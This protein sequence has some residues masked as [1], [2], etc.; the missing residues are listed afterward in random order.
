M[1]PLHAFEVNFL[2]VLVVNLI[3]LKLS[4]GR[5]LSLEAFQWTNIITTLKAANSSEKID[6]ID[7]ESFICFDK[8]KQQNDVEAAK[9]V[10]SR[11]RLHDGDQYPVDLVTFPQKVTKFPNNPVLSIQNIEQWICTSLQS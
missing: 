9:F 10:F 8:P 5:P 3:L 2:D 4:I 7:L 6:F 1:S 11:D